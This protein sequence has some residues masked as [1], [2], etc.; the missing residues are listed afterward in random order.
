MCLKT[1]AKTPFSPRD[2]SPLYCLVFF[3][4]SSSSSNNY[5]TPLLAVGAYRVICANPLL[6][7]IKCSSRGRHGFVLEEPGR[8]LGGGFTLFA[9][10]GDG[11]E[12]MGR[13]R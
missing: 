5:V 10:Y 7:D 9:L 13:G 6:H 4:F 11:G 1:L 12:V 8:F 3:F 2:D